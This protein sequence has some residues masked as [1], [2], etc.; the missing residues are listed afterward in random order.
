MTE[1]KDGSLMPPPKLNRELN[2]VIPVDGTSKGTIHVHSTPISLEV[3]E[4]Y[5]EP[6]AMAHAALY[7]QDNGVLSG[8]RIAAMHL[9]KAADRLG[10][11]EEVDNG[12]FA[13]IFRLTNVAAI[14]AG[15]GWVVYPY[16]EARNWLDPRDRSQ[17]E[18]AIAFFIVNSA[19]MPPN[20][21]PSILGLMTS[22]WG[23]QTTSSNCMEFAASLTKS[24]P[25]AATPAAA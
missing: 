20:A 24:T 17:V 23:A 25:A 16:H 4:Q 14:E 1:G 2:L 7:R 22:L 3:F 11:R 8:P 21:L 19:V 9:R 18:N 5:F 10:V 15:K 6:I 13:E 12:L